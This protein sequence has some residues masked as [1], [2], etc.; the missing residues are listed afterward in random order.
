MSETTKKRLPAFTLIA[1]LTIAALLGFYFLN[2]ETAAGETNDEAAEAKDESKDAEKA[3][4]PVEAATVEAG[5][6]SAYTSATAN[7]VPENEVRVLAEWEGRVAKLYVE[8]GDRVGAG[9]VLVE[10][11]R[12]D[13]EILLNKA[14]VKATTEQLAYERAKKLRDQELL[15]DDEFD[16][17]ALGRE[18]A[19]Q[20]LAEAEWRLEKTQIRAPF[21]GRIV[22]RLVQ[23]GQHVR[24]GDELFA[25]ADFDPLI[26]RI[27]LPEKDVLSLTEGREVKIS[28]RADEA[29]AFAGRIRQISPV[30]DTATGTVK[31]TVEARSVPP[32]VRPGAFVRIDVVRDTVAE[33]VLV[34]REAV[35]RELQKAYVFV[36]ED[37]VASKRAVNLGIEED[38]FLE[39][40]SGVAAGE[41]VI[42]AGQGGLKDGTAVKLIGEAATEAAAVPAS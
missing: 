16:K 39:A 13:G 30:V 11:D 1:G 5:R 25:V 4:I 35:V 37:G 28:L 27:Y 7:L 8:E 32:Q 23:P 2:A 40:K 31:V 38:G 15:A 18:I 29:I 24:R 6:V 34:P 33:A 12:Q 17:V 22:E 3:P 19:S 41:Q 9:A 26:A 14:R 21:A 10:L 42:V 36:A 20:E